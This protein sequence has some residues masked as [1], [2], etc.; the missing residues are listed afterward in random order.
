MRIFLLATGGLV[1]AFGIYCLI[2]SCVLFVQLRQWAKARILDIEVDVSQPGEFT[3]RFTPDCPFAFSYQ[4]LLVLPP[5]LSD[6]LESEDLLTGMEAR[7]S[8]MDS[9][10]SELRDLRDRPIQPAVRTPGKPI[11]LER[12][13]LLPKETH[14]LRLSVS[15]G[16]MALSG[17]KQRLVLKYLF[18]FQAVAWL[19][20]LLVSIPA[21]AVG[22]ILLFAGVKLRDT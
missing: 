19:V 10:G 17:T 6:R 9:H 3:G 18:G 12:I 7:L 21:L 15:Q 8:V 11:A 4:L 20:G 1:A 22:A 13:Y 2:I 16:A 14:T 5:S